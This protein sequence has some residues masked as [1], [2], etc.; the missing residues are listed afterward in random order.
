MSEL[1]TMD[2]RVLDRT[3]S[4]LEGARSVKLTAEPSEIEQALWDRSVRMQAAQAAYGRL[5]ADLRHVFMALAG[6]KDGPSAA[7]VE[8]KIRSLLRAEGIDI[9]A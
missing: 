6:Q 8:T 9:P 4:R 2:G 1:K 5:D 7:Q 3:Q